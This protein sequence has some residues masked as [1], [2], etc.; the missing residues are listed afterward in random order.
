MRCKKT[1]NV[2]ELMNDIN[3]YCI[4]CFVCVCV[5]VCVRARARAR[6]TNIKILRF[7]KK[8]RRE[9]LIQEGGVEQSLKTH[10][11]LSTFNFI[12]QNQ[13][14]AAHAG[15]RQSNPWSS[16]PEQLRDLIFARFV[17][18]FHR[19]PEHFKFYN[20]NAHLIIYSSMQDL[21]YWQINYRAYDFT[22]LH[23]RIV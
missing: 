9:N 1:A 17:A 7:R 13:V 4:H 23:L 12:L 8:F 5:C 3:I 22:Y 2:S 6:V 14:Y 10:N 19:F 15:V 20:N 11:T 21:T 16:R 18:Y